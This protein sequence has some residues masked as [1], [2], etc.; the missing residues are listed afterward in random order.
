MLEAIPSRVFA[1]RRARVLAAL[2]SR[3]AL[4]LAAAPELRVGD[5]ELRYLPDPD[6]YYL[7]GCTE[8]EAVLVLCPGFAE[9]PCT[10]FV[11]D[12]DPERELWTGVRGGVAGASERF[13]ADATHPIADL[14]ARLR[15]ILDGV[16]QLYYRPGVGRAP[17]DLLVQELLGAGRARR[18]RHG[19]GL[20]TIADPGLL[21][22]ELRLI[23]DEYELAALR[24]AARIT[25]ETFR[26]VQA[27]VCRGAGEWELEAALEGG[28]RRRGATGPAFPS[29]V[30]S[31]PNATVLHYV[32]NDRALAPGELVLI[33]AGARAGLYCAD[34]TRTWAVDG[35]FTTVQLELHE[36]VRAAHDAA[37]AAAVPGNTAAAPHDAAVRVLVEGLVALGLL[38]GD[39]AEL[40]AQ[41]DSY[42]RFYPHRTSHWLGL[43]T[44]D[45]GDYVRG[46]VARLLEPG[47]VLTIEPGLYLPASEATLPA[48][49][50][51]VGIRLENAVVITGDGHEVL[52]G[53][54]PI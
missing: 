13:G 17:L 14:P 16:D 23:K 9:A 27:L 19:V 33:D 3:G 39:P 43:D 52:T 35:R 38:A 29:I 12:R 2:G 44:H 1:A 21:L 46:G 11:R 15:R 7:S 53:E 45:V 47:M 4:L 28:F 22:D 34:M 20:H 42:R 8:P 36:I 50:R 54:L 51:G 6:L 5:A 10:L 37:L 40:A 48:A 32:A 25:V 26:E 30:A 24:E 41:P 31:G 18:P 49:L